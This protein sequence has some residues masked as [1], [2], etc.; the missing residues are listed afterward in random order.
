MDK[1]IIEKPKKKNQRWIHFSIS[2]VICI[3]IGTVTQYKA[4]L[5]VEQLTAKKEES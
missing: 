5:I 1:I 4:E 3:R 2:H